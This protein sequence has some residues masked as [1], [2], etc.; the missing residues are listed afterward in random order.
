M[1][2]RRLSIVWLAAAAV[3]SGS[4]GLEQ[5]QEIRTE[6]IEFEAGATGTRIQGSITGYGIVDYR[7]G[8]RAGQTMV[9]NMT[10]SSGANYFNVLAPGETEVAFFNGSI[11]ANAYAGRLSESGDYTIRVYQMRSAARRQETARYTLNVEITSAD[12]GER[13]NVEAQP[14]T[15]A[16]VPG[17]GFHAT[18]N[19]PCARWAG[20][21]MGSCLFGVVREG[22]GSGTVTVSWPDGGNRVLFF[23]NA[24]PVDFDRSEADGSAGMTVA[25]EADLYFVR[26]GDERFEIPEAVLTGG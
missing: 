15:D 7:L 8:A 23:E 21:P 4:A 5:E 12:H 18:G 26:I 19:I 10:T 24:T 3:V 25:Q 11:N 2:S 16:L 22:D 6:R 14:P 20:Q 13:G 17:T 1:A 9:V